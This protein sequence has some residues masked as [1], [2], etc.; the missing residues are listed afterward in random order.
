MLTGSISTIRMSNCSWERETGIW[1]SV[2]SWPAC[3]QLECPIVFVMGK[4][5]SAVSTLDRTAPT[6]DSN[7]DHTVYAV[8]LTVFVVSYNT[9]Y[10]KVAKKTF[11]LVTLI[12]FFHRKVNYEPKRYLYMLLGV[13][14]H[15]QNKKWSAG[16]HFIVWKTV[17]TIRK[18]VEPV[19]CAWE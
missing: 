3:S 14:H 13:S 16:R 19:K 1:Q 15:P 8:D 5:D 10:S 11:L 12:N 7:I 2:C 4:S 18:A 17:F 9:S 6:V